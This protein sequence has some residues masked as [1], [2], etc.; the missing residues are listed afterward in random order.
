MLCIWLAPSALMAVAPDDAGKRW[1]FVCGSL[2]SKWLALDAEQTPDGEAVALKDCP[3]CSLF[4]LY[5]AAPNADLF[6][7]PEGH[8]S[9]A[10]L[11]EPPQHVAVARLLRPQSPRAPPAPPPFSA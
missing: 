7:A 9:R 8:H 2:Q 5:D 3:L 4:K 10:Q 11:S 6:A 1:V